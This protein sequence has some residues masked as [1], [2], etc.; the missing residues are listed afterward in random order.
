MKSMCLMITKELV[1]EPEPEV[2]R[3]ATAFPNDLHKIRGDRVG[4]LGEND[5]IHLGPT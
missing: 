3:G 4:E 5:D 1:L 2:L